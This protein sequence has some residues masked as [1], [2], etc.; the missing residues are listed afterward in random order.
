MSSCS[1]PIVAFAVSPFVGEVLYFYLELKPRGIKEVTVLGWWYEGGRK[2][3]ERQIQYSMLGTVFSFHIWK[4]FLSR[5]AFLNQTTNLGLFRFRG[6][7][8]TSH[9]S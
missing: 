2:E 9:L 4:R 3:N 5:K 7:G 1:L 8:L 6:K